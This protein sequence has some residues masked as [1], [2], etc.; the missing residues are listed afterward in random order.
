[1][2]LNKLI[3]AISLTLVFVLCF[4][5]VA[6]AAEYSMRY[7]DNTLKR[8]STVKTVVKNVQ[9]DLSANTTYSLT[10]DGIFGTNTYYATLEFQRKYDDLDVDGEVG[11]NT[12]TKLY[13]KRDK[14]Y[15][16]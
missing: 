11:K 3:V 1:M 6:L 15:S 4:T 7:G 12:K 5:A 16:Y 14:D 2:K 13:P 9:A 8:S 10:H